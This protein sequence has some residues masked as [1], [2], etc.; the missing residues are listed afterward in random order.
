MQN[1]YFE[2]EKSKKIETRCILSKKK[3]KFAFVKK[4]IVIIIAITAV[5]VSCKNERGNY[6]GNLYGDWI[7]LES[8]ETWMRFDSDYVILNIHYDDKY[9]YDTAL[10]LYISASGNGIIPIE[11]ESLELSV[12]ELRTYQDNSQLLAV[13]E[14]KDIQGLFTYHMVMGVIPKQ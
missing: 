4:L 6:P 2:T 3:I 12:I 13:G 14:D 10:Y 9:V 8:E 5:L 11:E 1:Y 7:A